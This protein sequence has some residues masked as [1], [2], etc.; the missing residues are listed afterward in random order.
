[1]IFL[2][3]GH[4]LKDPGAVANGY[5][6]NQL[7]MQL[8]DTIATELQKLGASFSL[9]KD[10]ETLAEY[11]GRIKPGSG[12]VVCELHFNAGSATATGIEVLVKDNADADST[13]L[14]RDMVVSGSDIMKIFNRGV[15]SESQS[16][17]GR[18]GLLHIN[19]GISVLAEVCFIT[20]EDDM[21]KYKTNIGILSHTWAELLIKYDA[22]KT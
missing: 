9:D 20:N 4:H 2:S 14:A 10:T 5:R 11:L 7:T 15:R 12:S 13:S 19:A 6:E 22:L 1:M 16:H 3:A 18:L 17:R 8:R 21:R